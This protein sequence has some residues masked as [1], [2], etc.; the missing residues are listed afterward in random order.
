MRD[1][2]ETIITRNRSPFASNQNENLLKTSEDFMY[3]AVPIIFNQTKVGEFQVAVSKKRIAKS[4]KKNSIELFFIFA[5]IIGAISLIVF[6]VIRRTV[7]IPVTELKK[8]AQLIAEGD[9]DTSIAINSHDEIGHLAE[10]LNSMREAIQLF[11]HDL[12]KANQELAMI[13][14]NL[15]KE[16]R[17]K[18]QVRQQLHNIEWLL[19]KTIKPYS[20]KGQFLPLYGDLVALNTKRVIL[21][22][23]GQETLSNIVGD[24]LDLL[25]TSS[26]VYETNG[27]YALGIFSS[28]WCRFLDNASRKLCATEDNQ[29]AL[30]SGLWLCHE[31]CWTKAS[32]AAIDT[33][34]PTDIE[35]NGGL[36][37]YA[38]PIESGQETI[39]AINFGYGSPPTDRQKLKEIADKYGVEIEELLEKAEAYETR[40][41]YILD[42]ARKRLRSAAK[43]IGEI[44]NRKKAENLLHI[45]YQEMEQRVQDRTQELD[46]SNKELRR[47]SEKQ[48]VLLREV[49]HRVKNNLTAIISMLH[50]EE[51]RVADLEGKKAY[52]GRLHDLV[53]RVSG[54]L[55]VHNLLSSARWE[56]LSLA[57]LCQNMIKE[58]SKGID[59][60]KIQFDISPSDVLV[61]SDQAHYLAIVLNELTTNSI[62]YAL[63]DRDTVKI[64]VSIHRQGD[65]IHFAYRDDGPGYPEFVFEGELPQTGMGF[66]LIVGMVKQSL[67]GRIELLNDAGA[68]V[69][70]SFPVKAAE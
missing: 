24:F 60:E 41:Q 62:K 38:I 6:M 58:A 17:E 50:Q 44:V 25:E 67:E 7:V 37:L 16:M 20:Q 59:N 46:I 27:D 53:G 69:K 34:Q 2:K 21:D 8:S 68:M 61:N 18:E 23:V 14:E 33:G 49:N 40:P 48:V 32:K 1:K 19:E 64:Q 47:Y 54:L 9:L 56:P 39:G 52:C 15:Q 43:L 12:R 66:Y 4:V 36:R 3:R 57:K 28:G 5:I 55:T 51:D 31:S 42:I 65:L 22:F 63:Q 26:A 45:A 29:E 30:D 35:C 13:V 10:S 70:I 11:S